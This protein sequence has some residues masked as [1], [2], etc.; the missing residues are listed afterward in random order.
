MNTE[1][2]IN[3]LAEVG[4]RLKDCVC[5]RP[6]LRKAG[7]GTGLFERTP[8]IPMTSQ[9]CPNTH[10]TD[11]CNVCVHILTVPRPPSSI[12]PAG[13]WTQ[14]FVI[15]ALDRLPRTTQSIYLMKKTS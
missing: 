7:P 14:L 6:S 9:C 5:P 4:L 1:F 3:P 15:G 13:L 11:L 8:A 10:R 12:P 2:L